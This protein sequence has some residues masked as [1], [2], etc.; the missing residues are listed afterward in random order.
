MQFNFSS[1]PELL[2]ERL[3][4][5]QLNVKDEEEIFELRSDDV[6]N[7]YLDRPKAKSIKDAEDFIE[8]INFGI[9]NRQSFFWAICFRHQPK[10]IGTICLW[11]F[12]E[13]ENKAEVGYELLPPFHGKGIMQE[14]FS[15]VTEFG[16]QTLQLSTIE[17]WTAG[18]NENSIK[19]LER[20]H[21]KRDFEQENKIDRAK[22]GP[23]TVIYSLSKINY[24]NSRS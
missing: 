7:K 16:F 3:L 12:S 10:L 23:D 15:K 24:L 20:N 8:R 21:F 9:N 6:V 2:T 18:Q 22:E 19:L 14:A 4:L 5:R 17:A 11:N 13:E 1:F